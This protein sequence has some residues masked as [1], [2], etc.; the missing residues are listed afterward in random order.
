MLARKVTSDWIWVE[1]RRWAKFDGITPAVYPLGMKRYG[2]VI[3]VSMHWSS[4]APRTF[5][6]AALAQSVRSLT[7][8]FGPMVPVAPAAASVWHELQVPTPLKTALPAALAAPD[9]LGDGLGLGGGALAVGALGWVPGTPGWFSPGGG[10]PIGG[11]ALAGW[12][13]SQDWNLAGVTT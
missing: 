11:G 1:L 10:V 6:E 13:A 5:L 3:A 7:S 8:R 4:D 9:G 2:L 12:A